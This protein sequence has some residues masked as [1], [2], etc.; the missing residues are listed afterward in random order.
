MDLSSGGKGSIMKRLP[1]PTAKDRALL[2]E[3]IITER[4]ICKEKA[5]LL[6]SLSCGNSVDAVKKYF[7]RPGTNNYRDCPPAVWRSFNLDFCGVDIGGGIFGVD[8]DKI[9]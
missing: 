8:T 5:Y 2:L 3:Q 7:R 1:K 6:L 4:Q 9:V